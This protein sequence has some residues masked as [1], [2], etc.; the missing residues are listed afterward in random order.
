MHMIK[1]T[2]CWMSQVLF[3]VRIVILLLLLWLW[4]C[5]FGFNVFVYLSLGGDTR[6]E[7]LFK[8]EASFLTMLP[9]KYTFWVFLK[10]AGAWATS[11]SNSIFCCDSKRLGFYES[12]QVSQTNWT[13]EKSNK[14]R[15]VGGAVWDSFRSLLWESALCLP[16]IGL[17][18]SPRDDFDL[19]PLCLWLILNNKLI[20]FS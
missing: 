16:H 13:N 2:T 11:F 3:N 1:E 5:L 20:K 14:R 9:S 10:G 4:G 12:L 17:E 8:H 15:E 6:H 18:H 7:R 19:D